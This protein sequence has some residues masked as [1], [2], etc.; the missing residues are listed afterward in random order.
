MSPFLNGI[1]SSRPYYVALSISVLRQNASHKFP[2]KIPV[3]NI[4]S[5]PALITG[6]T[7]N[8]FNFHA[9]T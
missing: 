3:E 4:S 5:S 1:K 2:Q 7:T 6:Q 8:P 9:V